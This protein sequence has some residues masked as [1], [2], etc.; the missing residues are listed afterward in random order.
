MLHCARKPRA[1]DSTLEGSSKEAP[2]AATSVEKTGLP[3]AIVRMSSEGATTAS[4][5]TPLAAGALC[6]APSPQL[7]A[8]SADLAEP[9]CLLKMT[10]S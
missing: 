2:T 6:F 7:P 4:C 3:A 5:C 8:F 1:C 9:G 10:I